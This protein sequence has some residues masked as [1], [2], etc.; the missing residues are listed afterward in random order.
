MNAI[1]KAVSYLNI[2]PRTRAQVE[3]YLKDKGYE[4]SEIEEAVT[5]LQDYNYIDDLN[6]ARMYFELG[7]E[8][9][10]GTARISRE[11]AEKGVPRD[12]INRAYQELE[13]VPDQYEMALDI[14]RNI[15]ESSLQ[16]RDIS[17]L[18]YEAVHKLQAKIARRL[19]SR[20]F[21]GDIVY[22][23]AGECTRR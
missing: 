8:K 18:D 16:G 1:D 12:V 5:S 17:E 9:G 6:F 21:E 7:F 20:G 22:R 23:V 4:H 10:R 13:S 3:K 15:V 19:A 2:K 11:L 14:G